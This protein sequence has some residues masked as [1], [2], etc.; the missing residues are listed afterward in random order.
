VDEGT[1]AAAVTMSQ[2]VNVVT[3]V[4]LLTVFGLRRRL[5]GSAESRPSW[6]PG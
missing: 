4:L 2:I 3:T 6:R 5:E 1:I